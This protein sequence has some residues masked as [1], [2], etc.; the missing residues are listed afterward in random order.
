MHRGRAPI[1]SWRI[2]REDLS[3]N[4]CNHHFGRL[5]R[6]SVHAHIEIL[7]YIFIFIFIYI[8]IDIDIIFSS[9]EHWREHRVCTRHYDFRP[10][11]Q[12]WM[13]RVCALASWLRDL[14]VMRVRRAADYLVSGS[15]RKFAIA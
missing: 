13:D 15:G 3:H 2:S 7:T 8:C 9:A 4:S 11:S 14:S 6:H 12:Q 1:Q 10:A 5:R